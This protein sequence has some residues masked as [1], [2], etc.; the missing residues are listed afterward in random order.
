MQVFFKFFRDQFIAAKTYLLT[1][2]RKKENILIIVA[3]FAALAV[4]LAVTAAFMLKPAKYVPND[5][6][7]DDVI[8]D[9]TIRHPLTGEVLEAQV[10]ELPQVFAVMIEN[11]ADAWPLSGLEDAFLVIEAPVEGNIPRFITFFSGEQTADA[12]VTPVAKIGP[13]RSARPYYLDWSAEFDSIYAHVGGSPEALDLISQ[14]DMFDLNEF[15]QGEYFWRDVPRRQAPHNVYTSTDRLAEAALELETPTSAY[16]TWL[17][18]DDSPIGAESA[19]SLV[20]DWGEGSLYDV[21][22]K[23]DPAS[24]DYTRLQDGIVFKTQAG[25]NI[26]ANNVAVLAS[27]VTVVDGVGRRHIRTLGTGDALVV[28]D[29]TLILGTWKKD[30]IEDRIRFYDASGKEIRMNAGKTWIEIVPSLDRA[31]TKTDLQ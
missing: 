20:I 14:R 3:V 25:A 30:S 13:V 2:S 12:Q 22:W 24:N 18:K 29:G 23:Y 7:G 10:A 9:S 31:T 5:V 26:V 8:V 1:E 16:G 4:M 27:D 15:F 19:R 17:F 28:Q 6:G 21:A 11:S